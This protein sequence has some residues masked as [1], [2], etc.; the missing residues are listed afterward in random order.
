MALSRNQRSR[1]DRR[2]EARRRL[3][4]ALEEMLD[5][6]A[7]F[8]S[9]KVEDLAARAGISRAGFYIHFQDKVELLEQ[10]LIETRDVLL[11][12]SARWYD[13]APAIQL[14]DLRAAITDIVLTYRERMTLMAAM[15]EAALYDSTLREDF[16]QAFQ[17][18]F[19][20]L[21]AH[22]AAGQKSGDI[23]GGLHPRETAE[24]LV[25][26]IERAPLWLR[27]KAGKTELE[28]Q[29]DAAADVV[30]AALYEAAPSRA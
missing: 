19:A 5:A 4:T 6:G 2:D 10:W 21:T 1:S 17:M 14:D 11:E 29:A 28:R 27:E 22:I 3:L 23:V 24:W 16:E 12:V 18:H 7:S 15:H 20:A 26:M 25:C 9:V 8:A 30:W 13:A